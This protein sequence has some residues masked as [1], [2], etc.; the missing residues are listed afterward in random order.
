MRGRRG[1]VGFFEARWI[2]GISPVMTW[3]RRAAPRAPRWQ[4][5]RMQGRAL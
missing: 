5:V 2:T 3:W 1:V 4:L